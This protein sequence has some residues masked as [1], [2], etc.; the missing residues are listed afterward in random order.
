MTAPEATRRRRTAAMVAMAAAVATASAVGAV[1]YTHHVQSIAD[2]RHAV[3]DQVCARQDQVIDV[4]RLLA[5]TPAQHA[6]IN[7]ILASP[8]NA[9]E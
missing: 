6:E 3:V 8:C 4:L 7:A 9:T 5:T 2:D 1:A